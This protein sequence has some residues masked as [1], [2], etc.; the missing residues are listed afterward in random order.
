MFWKQGTTE[1]S[2]DQKCLHNY[3]ETKSWITDVGELFTT[4]HYEY[5]CK[6]CGH[7]FIKAQRALT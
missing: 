3:S 7:S 6:K 5:T 2:V 1:K 4:Y